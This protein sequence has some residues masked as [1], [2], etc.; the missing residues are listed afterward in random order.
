M[1]NNCNVPAI[2][3]IADGITS[4][5]GGRRPR[6]AITLGSGLGGYG[7]D[8]ILT[9]IEYEW[10]GLPEC[11][12]KGHAGILRV[13]PAGYDGADLVFDGRVH[14]YEGHDF[15]TVVLG[16]RAATMAGFKTHIITCASGSVNRE[17]NPPEVVIIR[18]HIN[19]MGGSPLVGINNNN[20]GTRFPDMTAAYD[21]QLM[22]IATEAGTHLGV[23]LRRCVYMANKGPSYETPAEVQMARVLGADL[24]GMSTVP[25]VIA[26]RHTGAR[27]LAFSCVTNFAAGV[28][29]SLLTHQEVTSNAEKAS[30]DFRRL[31]DE[32]RSRL[33]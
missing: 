15:Q 20:V 2:Q 32:T 29:G 24:V 30:T 28:T 7:S 25:E 6:A 12:I 21:E 9:K 14:C 26:L 31:L 1:E 10:L 23:T 18:D 11:R 16:V 33:G 22:D 3:A 19:N 17:I 8:Q 13:I 4:R 27:V 5:L